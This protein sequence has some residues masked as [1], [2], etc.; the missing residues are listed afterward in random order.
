MEV[1]EEEEEVGKEEGEEEKEKEEEEE[2]EEYLLRFRRHSETKKR[3]RDCEAKM[4][5]ESWAMARSGA[6][7]NAFFSGWN[8]TPS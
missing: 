8:C 3:M 5:S 1:R 6:H 4:A 2:E 7:S